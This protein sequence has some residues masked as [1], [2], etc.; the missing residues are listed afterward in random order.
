MDIDL[1]TASKYLM[2]VVTLEGKEAY[3]LVGDEKRLVHVLM[4]QHDSFI[5]QF[6]NSWIGTQGFNCE[7]LGSENIEEDSVD[8]DTTFTTFRFSE[9]HALWGANALPREYRL[10]AEYM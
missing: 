3:V 7:V 4:K 1:E 6:G 8:T 9:L 2:R 5:M 10:R